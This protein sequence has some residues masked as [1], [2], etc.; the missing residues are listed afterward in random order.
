MY[1][2]TTKIVNHLERLKAKGSTTIN[3]TYFQ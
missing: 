1:Y 2:F 3:M